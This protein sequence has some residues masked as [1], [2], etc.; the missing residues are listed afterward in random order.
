MNYLNFRKKYKLLIYLI[1][2]LFLTLSVYLSLIWKDFMFLGLGIICLLCF[3]E[4]KYVKCP[5]CGKKPVNLFRQFPRKCPY[6][7]IDL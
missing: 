7:K 6:C 3:I 1:G 4:A 2:F 5:N